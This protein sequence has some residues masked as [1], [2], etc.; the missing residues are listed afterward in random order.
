MTE[1]APR[2]RCTLPVAALAGGR[3][4]GFTYAQAVLCPRPR[5]CALPPSP[6]LPPRRG[7]PMGRPKVALPFSQLDI[8]RTAP[9]WYAQFRS[10]G[11]YEIVPDDDHSQVLRVRYPRGS[12]VPSSRG[13]EGGANFVAMPRG[14]PATDVTLE[15]RVRFA[16]SFNW[17]YGGK[18]PGLLV[19]E[20][21]ATGGVRTARAA[22]CRVMW[23]R[24]GA[25]IAYV[26]LPQGARPGS[27]YTSHSTAGAPYG[28]AVFAG[29][30]PGLR[31]GAWNSVVVRVKLNGF[32][33]SGRPVS[34]G[35]LTLSINGRAANVSGIVWRRYPDVLITKILFS[36]F[37]GGKWTAPA[38]THADFAGVALV[39]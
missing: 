6:P 11:S 5:A 21:A 32:D 3:V 22:S 26:Y 9:P 35:E 30:L 29:Q 27:A 25:V 23:Q 20:G 7:V 1:V 18:L 19:G 31:R 15:Y 24:G 4:P 10:S 39:T 2:A 36:T 13:P 12:G 17:S 8:D 33:D 37:Y 38:T 16:P 28:D 34:D 14:L